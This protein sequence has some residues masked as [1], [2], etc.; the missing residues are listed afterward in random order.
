MK[1]LVIGGGQAG[2]G[3]AVALRKKDALLEITLVDPKDYFE[4]RWASLRAMFD[5]KIRE[6]YTVLYKDVCG[7]HG[8]THT[9]DCV[10]A[11]N[12]QS[13]VLES[14][15]EATVFDVCIV[16][17][18][19][20]C[21]TLGVDPIATELFARK[22]ELAAAG[23][24]LVSGTGDVLVVGGGTLGCE[25]AGEICKQVIGAG[26]KVIVAQSTTEIVPEMSAKGRKL[27]AKV[28]DRLGV[29]VRTSNR[30]TFDSSSKNWAVG[31]KVLQPATVIKCTGYSA[32]NSFMTAGDLGATCVTE[33]GWINTDEN[34]RVMGGGADGRIFAFGDC[35]TTGA[36][37][38]TVIQSNYAAIVHNV[39]AKLNGNESKL[40]KCSNQTAGITVLTLG[41][42]K[43]VADLPFGA[44]KSVLPAFKNK[45]FFID[46]AKSHFK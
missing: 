8:I 21:P 39:R 10:V 34:F 15:G 20:T 25:T 33:K 7:K 3:V 37:V 16:A 35:C 2:L 41:P 23:K 44:F 29:E 36:N 30:A 22:E 5:E 45:T 4:V 28:M 19:A 6:K 9:K 17:V 11:L 24:Q 12:K 46:Q 38:G 40:K 14:G 32:R 27:T 13:A 43:G 18:G 42:D 26:H 1:V 31:N